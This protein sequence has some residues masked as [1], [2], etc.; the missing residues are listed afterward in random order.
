MK[1][2]K[3]VSKYRIPKKKR[4]IIV[5]DSIEY[6]Y[7]I[8]ST[9]TYT[10]IVVRNTLTHKTLL[11]CMQGFCSITPSEIRTL[12]LTSELNLVKSKGWR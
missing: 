8:K 11:W 6:E 7:T 12:I 10:E 2:E 9:N 5:I 1:N 4:R 3:R